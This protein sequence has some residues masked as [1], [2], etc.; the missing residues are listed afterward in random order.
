M[1]I[2]KDE[3]DEVAGANRYINFSG[4]YDKFYCWKEKKKAIARQRES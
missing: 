1:S 4:E 3:G 2:I